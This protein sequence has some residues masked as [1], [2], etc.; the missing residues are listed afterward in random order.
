[1]EGV[2]RKAAINWNDWEMGGREG[3]GD[4]LF[5]YQTNNQIWKIETRGKWKVE[6]VTSSSSSPSFNV[7]FSASEIKELVHPLGT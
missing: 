3:G 2:L 5:S 1:M 4:Q 7:S 6:N